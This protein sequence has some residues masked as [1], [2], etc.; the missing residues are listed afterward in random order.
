MNTYQEMQLR[1][2]QEFNTLPLGFAFNKDQFDKM[3]R[4]WGLHPER[5]GCYIQKKDVE[6]LLQT[7]VRHKKELAAAIA[8]DTTGSG[9]IFEM[10][11]YE[12]KNYEYGYTEDAEDAL[13][14]LGLTMEQVQS[15]KLLC[16]GFER[17]QKKIWRK[18][19][20]G[21]TDQARR[22]YPSGR[23]RRRNTECGSALEWEV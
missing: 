17:A 14:A 6:L 1:Q 22:A 11:Y 13:D 20:N 4:G 16:R 8:A 5:D 15:D 12:L 3:M 10:F 7:S 19:R 9:F 2:Q 21:N 18:R 23:W